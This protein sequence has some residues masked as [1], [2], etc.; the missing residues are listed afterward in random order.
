MNKYVDHDYVDSQLLDCG[1]NKSMMSK[2]N[3]ANLMI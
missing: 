3:Y 2:Q 1:V